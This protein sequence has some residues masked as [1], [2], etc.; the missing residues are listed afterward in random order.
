MVRGPLVGPALLGAAGPVAQ[1]KQKQTA[2]SMYPA[3]RFV[4]L[5]NGREAMA[6]ALGLLPAGP[7]A[8]LNI[9]CR[10]IGYYR[11]MIA[12]YPRSP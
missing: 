2:T 12:G 3:G 9:F 1:R 8:R 11:Q 6:I 5:G 4:D 7:S 10:E